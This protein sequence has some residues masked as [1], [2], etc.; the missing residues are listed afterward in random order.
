MRKFFVQTESYTKFT[1]G[2][3]AV[4]Q[5]GAAEA[6]LMLVHGAPGYGKTHI[7]EHW[8]EKNGA[9]FLRANVDWTPK[10]FLV[11]LAKTMKVDP[12]GTAQQLFERLL[13]PIVEQQTPI[14]IDEAEFT[15]A[16][17]AA[18]LEKVRDFTDRAE[19][20]GV[21]I[22]MEKILA[23]IARFKQIFSRI[24]QVVQFGPASLEDVAQACAQLGEVS[25]TPAMVAE[26][27][28][29]SSGRMRE[30][31]NI[32]PVV[33]RVARLNGIDVVDVADMAGVPLSYDWQSQSH[34]A[35][36][37]GR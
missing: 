8:A 12:T 26:V 27:H 2:I 23:R 33:E 35:V 30:V 22:G 15:L 9:I 7:V 28:R 24:A 1:T 16:N 36:K 13:E 11:E 25:M 6:G 5:R 21:I 3:K 17:N 18:V 31:L 37:K 20:T 32:I 10:Y 14:V 29:L 19:V 4:E 34:R